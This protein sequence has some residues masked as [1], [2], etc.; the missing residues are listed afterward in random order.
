[1]S[2]DDHREFQ[3]MVSRSWSMTKDEHHNQGASS[4]KLFC[5]DISGLACGARFLRNPDTSKKSSV[6]CFPAIFVRSDRLKLTTVEV[7]Y[8]S[9][10]TVHCQMVECKLRSITRVRVLR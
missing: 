6:F 8:Y 4:A 1:M 9:S 5:T 7:D 10:S 3:E 2:D